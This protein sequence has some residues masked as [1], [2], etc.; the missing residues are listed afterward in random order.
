MQTIFLP[1]SRLA[2]QNAL[3]DWLDEAFCFPYYGRNLDALWDLI[4]ATI[5]LPIALIWQDFAKSQ[6][7]L[8]D[9]ADRTRQVFQEAADLRQGFYFQVQ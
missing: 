2:S 5:P 7:L 1:G 9:Y 3:H 4:S 8:G 6:V